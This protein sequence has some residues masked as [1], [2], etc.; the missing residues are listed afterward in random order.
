MSLS[1]GIFKI[2]ECPTQL[3]ATNGLHDSSVIMLKIP[4]LFSNLHNR[5]TE[6]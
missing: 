3:T 4:A 1:F 6:S 2:R 5:L